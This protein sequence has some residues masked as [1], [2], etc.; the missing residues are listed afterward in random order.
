[1]FASLFSFKS[2]AADCNSICKTANCLSLGFNENLG[3]AIQVTAGTA[4]FFHYDSFLMRKVIVRINSIPW[5]F[6]TTHKAL[7]WQKGPY[8]PLA[9]QLSSCKHPSISHVNLRAC[10]E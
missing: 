6:Y 1:M 5:N 4:L 9:I 3:K 10:R 8:L 2:H 7:F